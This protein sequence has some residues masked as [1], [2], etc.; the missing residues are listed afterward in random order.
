MRSSTCLCPPDFEYPVLGS[1]RPRSKDPLLTRFD[2]FRM[3]LKER[4]VEIEWE[5]LSKALVIR[6]L[7]DARC[8][9]RDSEQARLLGILRYIGPQQQVLLLNLSGL[10]HIDSLGIGSLARVLVECVKREIDLRIVPPAGAV[11]EALAVV[12]I[13]D[14]QSRFPDEATAMRVAASAVAR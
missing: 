11:G 7:G 6:V 13:L 10:T 3:L 8:W 12:K 4:A 5:Q 2:I 1:V 9:G 14:G